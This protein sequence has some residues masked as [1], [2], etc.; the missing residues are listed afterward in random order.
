MQLWILPPPLQQKR[1]RS[2]QGWRR[3]LKERKRFPHK[4]WVCE[5]GF[6]AWKRNLLETW[7][8]SLNRP[9]Q[10]GKG[11]RD[12]LIIAP[13]S[14]RPHIQ[15]INQVPALNKIGVFLVQCLPIICFF[16]LSRWCET[17]LFW[18]PVTLETST[19]SQRIAV[20]QYRKDTQVQL[21]L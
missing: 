7:S 15:P 20:A 17:L 8:Q 9:W 3:Q 4:P 10:Q 6:S 1:S 12:R 5:Q 16:S 14:L 18:N 2:Q 13:P 11:N 21:L 19:A